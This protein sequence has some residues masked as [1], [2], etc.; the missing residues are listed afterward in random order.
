MADRLSLL[1]S[2]KLSEQTVTLPTAAGDVVE[3]RITASEVMAPELAAKFPQIQTFQGYRV[4]RPEVRV[5]MELTPLG[6]GAMVFAPDH[7]ELVQPIALG[8]RRRH[9]VFDRAGMQGSTR[10]ACGFAQAPINQ[11]PARRA[12]LQSLPIANTITGEQTRS[13]RTVVAATGEYTAFFGGTVVGGVSAI[14][15]AM[16]RV[17]QVYVDLGVRMILV[18]NNNLVVYT[19][20]ITDPYTNDDGFEMLDENQANVDAV[21]GSAN[22]DIGHVFSTGGG[23]VAALGVPC[24][25]GAKAQGVTGRSS[26]VG[27]PF[28]VDYVAHE[29]GHQF[30]GPHTFNGTSGAC[31]DGNRDGADAYEPGSGSTIMAYAGICD[32]EDLQPNSDPYFHAGSLQRIQAYISS[33][34]GSSCAITSPIGGDPPPTIDAGPAATIPAST[35]FTLQGSGPTGSAFT[36]TYEQFNLGTAA[37]PNTDNGT[38]AIFRSFNPGPSPQ[39]TVPKLSTVLTP[40]ALPIGEAYPTSNR[41]LTFRLTARDA[42]SVSTGISISD[43]VNYTVTAAAGPFIVTAPAAGGTQGSTFTVNWNV[44]GTTAAPVGCANVEIALSTDNGL[45]FPQ[46]LAA[47]TPNDGTQSVTTATTTNGNARVRVRCL[48]QPFFNV[49]P[50]NFSIANIAV[51]ANGFE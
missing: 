15:V 4:D 33:P 2:K 47:S 32:A 24:E 38:R 7:V 42:R 11:L 25:T 8:E 31:G 40:P 36:Y 46:V 29:I 18:A 12:Q 45:S 43:D 3:F 28:Y 6:F 35:P 51:F 34:Q 10:Q 16:N 22:Y 27:D 39:R 50:G 49:N 13:Y 1:S 48:S 19:N 44:A 17:N 20:A 41:T 37:P 9:I 23:G 30:G 5:R 21:I 14:V 26:P